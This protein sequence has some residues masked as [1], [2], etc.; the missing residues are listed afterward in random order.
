MSDSV[1]IA[2]TVPYMTPQQYSALTGESVSAIKRKV[3]RGVYPVLPREDEQE[4]LLIN[5]AL[6]M[7]RALE[8]KF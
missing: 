8:A 1:N 2:L 5:V 7:R 3:A 6:L 4:R